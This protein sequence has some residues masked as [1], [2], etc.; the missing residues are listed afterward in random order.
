[1]F[2]GL[3]LI[4]NGRMCCGIVGKDL[5]CARDRTTTEHAQPPILHSAWRTRADA[6]AIPGLAGHSSVVISVH[7]VGRS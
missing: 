6:S 1:M 5:S 4:V 7:P 3:A 2:G